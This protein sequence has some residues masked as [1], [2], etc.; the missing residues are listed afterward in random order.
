MIGPQ[1]AGMWHYSIENICCNL[2]D[3]NWFLIAF[4]HLF[5]EFISFTGDLYAF[6]KNSLENVMGPHNA[7]SRAPK[8][9]VIYITLWITTRMLYGKKPLINQKHG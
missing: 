4:L 1:N 3:Y 9:R 2:L 6:L 7:G 5:G 8:M